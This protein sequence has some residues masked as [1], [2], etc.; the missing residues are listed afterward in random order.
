MIEPQKSS[1]TFRC[2]RDNLLSWLRE[3]LAGSEGVHV[4]IVVEEDADARSS[5]QITLHDLPGRLAG[6]QVRPVAQ[7]R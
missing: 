4:D 3:V 1:A 7:P 6:L 5:V 2:E